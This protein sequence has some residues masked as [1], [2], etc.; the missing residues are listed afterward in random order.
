MRDL[1]R[2]FS[3]EATIDE[4]EAVCDALDSDGGGDISFEEFFDFTQKLT[5]HMADLGVPSCGGAFTSL[6]RLVSGND[7]SGWFLFGF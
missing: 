1:M 7:G 6:I 4:I 2:K 5:F 3:P